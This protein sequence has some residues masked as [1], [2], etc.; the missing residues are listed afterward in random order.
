MI[1]PFPAKGPCDSVMGGHSDLSEITLTAARQCRIRTG[2]PPLE[3]L[4]SNERFP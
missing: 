1:T 4:I 2:L 3:S